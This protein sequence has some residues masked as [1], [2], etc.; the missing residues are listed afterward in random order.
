MGVELE[1][2]QPGDGKTFPKAGVLFLRFVTLECFRGVSQNLGGVPA[3]VA[4][5][6]TEK[7]H[8]PSPLI[9]SLGDKLTMHYTGKFPSSGEVFDSSV[10]KG[11]PFQFVIGQGQV[12]KGWDEGVMKM[13]VG[14]KALLKCSS[15]Y[16]YGAQGAGGVIPPNADLE[17]EV[18]LIAIN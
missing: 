6:A 3:G 7:E 13:S 16:A 15:D 9:F 5:S 1:T 4:S 8:R 11:K 2:T 18:E 10:K 12:I 14:Q 17:F